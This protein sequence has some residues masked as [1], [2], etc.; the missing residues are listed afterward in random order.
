MTKASHLPVVNDLG[1][2]MGFISKDRIL[3]ELADLGEERS[4]YHEIPEDFLEKEMSEGLLQF[5]RDASKLPVLDKY[6]E[7]KEFWDKPRFLAEFSKLDLTNKKDPKFEE[8]VQKN[9]KR[10]DSKESIQWY[11]ELILS[12][13]PDGLLSTDVAG[14]TVFYNESFENKFLPLPFFKDS[15]E[16]AERFLRDLNRDL[17]ANYLRENDLNIES[18]EHSVYQLQSIVKELDAFVKIIT[19]RNANKVVGFLY[20][21]SSLSNK[22]DAVSKKGTVFPD[23]DEALSSKYPLERV[24]EEMESRYIYETLKRNRNNISHA[25][26][27]LAIPRTTLQNRIR[28]LKISEKFKEEAS[29]SKKIIPR[30]R[31]V[32]N[33]PTKAEPPK[34]KATPQKKSPAK[35]KTS[36]RKNTLIA[37]KSAAR[38]LPKA[39]KKNK[40]S[41]KSKK[42]R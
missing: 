22:L 12:N 39:K 10:R 8:L 18:K 7:R 3:R 25:A 23:L 14:N 32:V 29:G 5:F 40:S 4:E 6:G 2:L 38:K 41:Q 42:R 11:M 17:F 36:A 13:F 16:V 35:K 31:A 30:K 24:L 37:K 33:I 34:A 27:E 15:V 20:Q 28:Y 26:T 21:L 1:N 19:L 9:E